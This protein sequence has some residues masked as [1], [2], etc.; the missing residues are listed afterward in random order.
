MTLEIAI[1]L[2]TTLERSSQAWRPVLRITPA[3]AAR[4]RSKSVGVTRD[5]LRCS[6]CRLRRGCRSAPC[7]ARHPKWVCRGGMGCLCVVTRGHADLVSGAGELLDKRRAH[8][9]GADYGDLGRAP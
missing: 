8:V 7:P 4:C 3:H 9:A 1:L 6:A 5:S 2:L